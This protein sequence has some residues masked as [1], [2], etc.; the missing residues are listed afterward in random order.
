VTGGGQAMTWCL[1]GYGILWSFC[2]GP[3]SRESVYSVS[4]SATHT[5]TLPHTDI[6]WEYTHKNQQLANGKLF[7]LIFWFQ[8]MGN[9]CGWWVRI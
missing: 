8:I 6:R 9:L 1:Y 4:H 7:V 5:H 2:M 3:S